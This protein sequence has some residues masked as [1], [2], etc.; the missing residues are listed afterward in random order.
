MHNLDNMGLDGAPHPPNLAL[1]F[2]RPIRNPRFTKRQKA[3]IVGFLAIFIAANIIVPSTINAI[4]P[5]EHTSSI[6]RNASNED[7]MRAIKAAEEMDM[8]RVL[9]IDRF[10]PSMSNDYL[11]SNVTDGETIEFYRDRIEQ[12]DREWD[13]YDASFQYTA[14]CQHVDRLLLFP[15]VKYEDYRL[16]Y[17]MVSSNTNADFESLYRYID[18]D[19]LPREGEGYL[20]EDAYVIRQDL[21]YE[22]HIAS[23]YDLS[24]ELAQLVILDG[25]NQVRV[26]M[27]YP[28]YRTIPLCY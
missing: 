23:S 25:D 26:L 9:G 8:A 13:Q 12:M 7:E 6:E 21:E 2:A 18:L 20:L 24:N 15:S 10:R 22:E 4:I 11:W 1:G 19:G 27:V 5:G 3:S 16:E 17:T 14:E 28:Q